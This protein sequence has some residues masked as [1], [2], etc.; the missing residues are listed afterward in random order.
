MAKS[1]E[2][3]LV[4]AEASKTVTAVTPSVDCLNFNEAC[5]EMNITNVSGTLP[6][7]DMVIQHSHDNVNWSTLYTFSQKTATGNN[8]RYIPD[9]T[10]YGFLRYLRGSYTIGG[11][12]PNFTFSL[13][14]VA[15]E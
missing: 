1:N 9:G 8:V 14:I 12:T 13:N 4:Q 11:T 5:I 2:V 3:K 6:T 7:L 10:V 15:K